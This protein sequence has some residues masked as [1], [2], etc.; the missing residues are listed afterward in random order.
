MRIWTDL[1]H[2][3]RAAVKGILYVTPGIGQNKQGYSAVMDN[4]NI[5]QVKNDENGFVAH[6]TYCVEN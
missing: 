4:P 1:L 5:L 6:S 2:A 3:R